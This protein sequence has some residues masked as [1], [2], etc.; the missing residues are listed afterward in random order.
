MRTERYL[1]VQAL[2]TAVGAERD[3]I[4]RD[5]WV[6]DG[7]IYHNLDS[8]VLRSAAERH[9]NLNQVPEDYGSHNILPC[10][11]EAAKEEK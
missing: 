7:V 3:D 8:K 10:D 11:I 2:E 9:R 1:L 5:I 6:I 4:L